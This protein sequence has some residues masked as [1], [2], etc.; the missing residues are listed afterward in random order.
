[1]K[2]AVVALGKIGLPLAVQMARMGVETVGSDISAAVVELVNQGIPP[3]P[4]EAGLPEGL[5]EVVSAGMLRATTSNQEAVSSADAVIVVVPVIVDGEGRPDFGAMDAAT[6]DIGEALRPKQ[7]ISYET[8]LP[9]GTTRGRFAP[10]LREAS[11]LVPGEDFYLVHS[12]ERVF[13]GRIFQDLRSYPKVVGGINEASAAAA[14]DFY[15]RILEF[16]ER[17][18]LP[19]PNGVWNLGSAES[20]ELTKLAETT[21]RDVN[22]ALAN[23]FARHAEEIGVDIGPV[24]EAANSQ[25]YS[26]IHR[27]GVAVGGHCI[28]VYPRFYS[29]VDRIARIPA[30]AREVNEAVPARVVD[31]LVREMGTLAGKRVVVL[32]AAYRGGVKETAFSGVFPLVDALRNAGALPLVHDPLYS[33]DELDHLGL[34]VYTTGESCDAAILQADHAEY[35]DLRPAD[36]PGCHVMFDGRRFLNGDRWTVDGVRYLRLGT[37]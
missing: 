18:E 5:A 10:L 22:I 16:D 29:S 31:I 15:E 32:G 33:E 12:P 21:Y 4:G 28:P 1:M 25:P 37:A 19:R 9:V 36:L 3:F 35:T 27:P 26:H 8:T 23:E 6:R 7:L 17:P 20:A 34:A 2:A 14:V 24:I 13:S 30:V 11:G